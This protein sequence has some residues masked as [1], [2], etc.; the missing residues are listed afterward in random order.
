MQVAYSGNNGQ[1]PR[2]ACVR[3]HHLHGTDHACQS[4]GGVRLERTIT[5]AF[6]DAVTPAGIRA[7]AQAI[8]EIEQQ[9]DERLT[10]QRLAVER[11][12]FEAGRARRQFDACEPE[13]RLVARTLETRYE[14]TLGSSSANAAS[15]PSSSGIAPSRSPPPSGTRWRRSPV[16]CRGCGVPQRRLTVIAKSCCAR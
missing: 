3:A 12:E 4:V 6:L 11:A 1:V 15:S 13:N 16:T 14:L 5:G 9:H 2:Y 7:S 10:G 8:E